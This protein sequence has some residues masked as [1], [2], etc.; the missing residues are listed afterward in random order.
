MN[1]V[2]DVVEPAIEPR[3]HSFAQRLAV[4]V[5]LIKLHHLDAIGDAQLFVELLR[6]TESLACSLDR[7]EIARGSADQNRTRRNHA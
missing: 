5:R 7:E 6:F 1:L 2:L 4:H 3:F